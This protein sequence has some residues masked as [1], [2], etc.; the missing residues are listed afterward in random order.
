MDCILYEHTYLVP[1]KSSHWP[2]S[3]IADPPCDTHCSDSPRLGDDDI[4]VAVLFAVVVKDV[5]GNLSGLS[6]TGGPL[7]DCDLVAL[8]GRKH[9]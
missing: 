7:N 4:A 2:A 8:N 1:T 9:L 6:T 3:F 5:L